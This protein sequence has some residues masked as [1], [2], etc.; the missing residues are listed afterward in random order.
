MSILQFSEHFQL[1]FDNSNVNNGKQ[2]KQKILNFFS[3]IFSELLNLS[4]SSFW[5]K[6]LL[7]QKL[8]LLNATARRSCYT[9]VRPF[10]TLSCFPFF[11]TNFFG[12]NFCHQNKIKLQLSKAILPILCVWTLK[13]SYTNKR[14][15]T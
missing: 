4:S 8:L 6:P 2:I 7:N 11:F 3:A 12:T 1:I 10:P 13:I 9:V 14:I 5:L 15:L